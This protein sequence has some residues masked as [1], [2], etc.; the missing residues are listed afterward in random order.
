MTFRLQR[1]G[2]STRKMD[3][4]DE[5]TRGI[6]P[7][8]SRGRNEVAYVPWSFTDMI[9][10]ANSLHDLSL[11]SN[12]F[13]STLKERTGVQLSSL[14]AFWFWIVR[15]KMWCWEKAA[16]H[17]GCL[18]CERHCR[19]FSCSETIGTLV[20]NSC[21]EYLNHKEDI[22]LGCPTVLIYSHLKIQ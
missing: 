18:D 19:H 11:G 17:S 7:I 8:L 6:Y 5:G 20:L 21:W 14:S 10:L 13:I 9:G 22:R 3:L 2:A 12:K 4:E 1:L 16:G 15:S